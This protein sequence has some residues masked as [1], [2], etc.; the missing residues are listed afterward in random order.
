M[1]H[2]QKLIYDGVPPPKKNIYIDLVV[3]PTAAYGYVKDF[4]NG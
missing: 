2:A 3:G 1:I 4:S